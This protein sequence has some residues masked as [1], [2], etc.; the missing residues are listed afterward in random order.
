MEFQKKIIK[1]GN[2]VINN[3]TD[4][5]IY[6]F[7][8]SNGYNFNSH[9]HKCYEFIHI[10][11][12]HFLYTVEGTDYILSD[13]DFIMTTPSELHAF[14]FPEE[15]DYQREF[16]HIYPGFLKDYPDLLD[17][18]NSR[19]IGYFNRFP[20]ETVKKYGIDKIFLGI[21]EC[22]TNVTPETDLLVLT[23][24]IQLIAKIKQVLRDESP[25]HQ[26]VTLNK[27]ANAVCD[28][29]DCNYKKNISLNTI[30]DAL[31]IS[32]EY[33][34]RIFKKETGMTVKTYLNMRR[35]TH[36]KSLIMQGQSISNTFR[37]CGFEDY[38]TFYRAF[39]KYV[40]ISPDEFRKTH[41]KKQIKTT[42]H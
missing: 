30:A 23:Y 14:S 6:C 36:A 1:Y 10:L 26:N 4:G 32:P 15:C 40:G 18:L 34:S 19:E 27:K 12:G 3:D 2:H 9:I 17:S 20:V 37:E 13:G 39:V 22:C 35:I 8:T 38:S 28:Y 31:F 21:E 25:A 41:N 5:Y 42:E 24:A 16:L 33:M 29:I 7:N 11:H